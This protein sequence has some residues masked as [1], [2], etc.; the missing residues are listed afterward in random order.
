MS[1]WPKPLTYDLPYSAPEMGF[2][3]TRT[4]QVVPADLARELYEAIEHHASDFRPSKRLRDAL[5]RYE[6]EVGK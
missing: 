5:A 1:E 4:T 2:P 3:H 6:A